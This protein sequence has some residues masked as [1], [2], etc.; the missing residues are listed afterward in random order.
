MAKMILG[1][2]KTVVGKQLHCNKDDHQ[3]V[4]VRMG[5]IITETRCI[6]DTGRPGAHREYAYPTTA[7]AKL[8]FARCA[9][10][11]NYGSDPDTVATLL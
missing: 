2:G 7:E 5:R 6:K 10:A 8:R 9:D 11:I 4:L 1:V 3:M